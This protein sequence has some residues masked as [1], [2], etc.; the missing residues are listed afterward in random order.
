MVNVT[1]TFSTGLELQVEAW[2]SAKTGT[3][4]MNFLPTKSRLIQDRD[5]KMVTT[6]RKQKLC[7]VK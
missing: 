5:S 1:S 2:N 6:G 7:F 4:S 3:Q